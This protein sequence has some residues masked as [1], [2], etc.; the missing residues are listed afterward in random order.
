MS[1]RSRSTSPGLLGLPG[2]PAPPG[3]PE[4]PGLPGLPDP[5]PAFVVAFSVYAGE[6]WPMVSTVQIAISYV[7]N[8]D[9][10][11]IV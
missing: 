7:V 8:D 2:L 1:A 11:L 5:P 9:R 6:A 10:P 3:P 4:L